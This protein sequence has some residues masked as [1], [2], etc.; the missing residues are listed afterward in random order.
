[1]G[2]NKSLDEGVYGDRWRKSLTTYDTS[3][4]TESINLSPE[5]HH[6][7]K[8]HSSSAKSDNSNSNS[9]SALF[10][11]LNLNISKEIGRKKTK[12]KAQNLGLT[13]DESSS[14]YVSVA[15]IRLRDAKSEQNVSPSG[16]T[17]GESSDDL[18]HI[19]IDDDFHPQQHNIASYNVN[20][21][22]AVIRHSKP[23]AIEVSKN[24]STFT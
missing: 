10:N 4:S 12:S 24:F 13:D 15:H 21:L 17:T 1:M 3:Q 2:R 11:G 20:N 14:Q 16:L 9:S 6:H 23:V 19:D 8:H 7:H 5:I 18:D 22:Y